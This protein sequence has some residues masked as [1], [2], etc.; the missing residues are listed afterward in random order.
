MPRNGLAIR[1]LL[2]GICLTP[3]DVWAE[4]APVSYRQV[5]EKILQDPE[6]AALNLRYAKMAIARN[7]LR[8]ALAAYE[9]I[10]AGDPKNVRAKA[11]LQRVLRLLKPSETKV[12]ALSGGQFESNPNR[13]S[14]RGDIES[15]G[16]FFGRLIVIDE[17]SSRRLR[18]RSFM[19]TYANIHVKIRGLDFGNVNLGSGPI[20]PLGN[21]WQVHTFVAGGYSWYDGQTFR[22]RA[23]SGL[24]FSP[25][26]PGLLH[27][28]TV[29]GDYDFIGKGFSTRD[30]YVIEVRAR[31]I[32]NAFL[33]RRGIATF[34]PYY[35]YNG[36]N[37]NGDPFIDPSGELYPLTYHQIGARW[38]YFYG[39]RNNLTFNANVSLEYRHYF[40][41]VLLETKNRRDILIAPGAEMIVAGLFKGKADLIF[42]YRF[43]Y[44]TSNDGYMRYGNHVAG[45]RMLWRIR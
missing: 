22:W 4:E 39:I 5:F 18:W 8:K 12:V 45:L 10:L 11:G 15:D 35:R 24:T 29:R 33:S 31:F 20:L 3:L 28:I 1:I 25:V 7:E 17:R 42:S 21:S 14:R 2:V 44:N 9:R 36:I 41:N 16:S 30:A 19:D 40:E 13:V 38:D 32:K 26:S 6:N 43:E 34:S 37:G 27:S 23:G